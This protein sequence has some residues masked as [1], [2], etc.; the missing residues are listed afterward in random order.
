MGLLLRA[1]DVLPHIIVCMMEQIE[2]ETGMLGTL[3]LG[4]PE[5]RQRSGIVVMT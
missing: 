4:G 2:K 3:L 5:P 1:Q